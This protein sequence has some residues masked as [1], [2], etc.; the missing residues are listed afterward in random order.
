[1]KDKF[2]GMKKAKDGK[3]NIPLEIKKET[4]KHYQTDLTKITMGLYILN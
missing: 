1:M 3:I 2:K 4:K